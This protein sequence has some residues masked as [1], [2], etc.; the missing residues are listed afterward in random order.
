MRGGVAAVA[1]GVAA[2]MS[3][4][5]DDSDVGHRGI[6]SGDAIFVAFLWLFLGCDLANGAKTDFSQR[7][8]GEAS[9][10]S[11][12][13]DDKNEE[14][15]ESTC[16][17]QLE[18]RMRS[19]GERIR[20]ATSRLGRCKHDRTEP[21][22]SRGRPSPTGDD[23]CQIARP[24]DDG[25]CPSDEQCPAGRRERDNEIYD[26]RYSTKGPWPPV[27]RLDRS[28]PPNGI[29]WSACFGAV[30]ISRRKETPRGHGDETQ[31]V[32]QAVGTFCQD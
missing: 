18:Q 1:N 19:C 5:S 2:A 6:G 31:T 14:C 11:K 4:T 26:G 9:V 10:G 13:P 21:R 3:R 8:G 29:Y 23:A 16:A 22:L 27:G 20:T 28:A 25:L 7:T 15:V 30:M 32:K 17:I 24:S 12:L